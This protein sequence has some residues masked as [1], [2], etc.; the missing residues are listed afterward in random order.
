MN[1]WYT[2]SELDI[3]ACRPSPNGWAFLRDEGLKRATCKKLSSRDAISPRA[4]PV[5]GLV[6]KA[7]TLSESGLTKAKYGWRSMVL[8]GAISLACNP[9]PNSGD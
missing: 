1:G 6:E 4:L 8:L 9:Q 5:Y 3:D 2:M 7:I